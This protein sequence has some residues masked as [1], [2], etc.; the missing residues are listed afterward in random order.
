[1]GV[2]TGSRCYSSKN[3]IP[4]AANSSIILARFP[5]NPWEKGG[6]ARF[7]F[8]LFSVKLSCNENFCR[9]CIL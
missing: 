3:P 7:R 9:F 4:L 5:I 2:T 1:M 6:S 8:I